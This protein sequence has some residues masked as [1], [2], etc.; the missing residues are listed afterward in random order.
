M[1]GVSKWLK[2]T[3]EKQVEFRKKRL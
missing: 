3:V 1:Q 2:S